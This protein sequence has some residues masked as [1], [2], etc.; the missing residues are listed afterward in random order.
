MQP[1]DWLKTKVW[2]ST[3]YWYMYP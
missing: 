2:E 1:K 3:I